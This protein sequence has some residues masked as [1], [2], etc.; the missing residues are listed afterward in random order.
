MRKAWFKRLG[1]AAVAGWLA[2]AG[3]AASTAGCASERE[4]INRVQPNAIRKSDLV[5]DFRDP[6]AAPEFYIRSVILA[7]HRTNPWFSDGLQDLTRRVRFEITDRFLIARNAYEFIKDSDGHGGVK[8]QANDGVVVSMWPITSHFQIQKS[9]N[10][11]TGE[12]TNVTEEN[13]T[14][15]PWYEREYM[16]VDWSRNLVSDPNQIFFWEAFA[17]QLTWKPVAYFENRPDHPESSNFAELGN[18]YFD[19]TSRWIASPETWDYYGY[20][21][22]SCLFR[23]GALYPDTYSEGSIDCG[24]QEVTLRTSF[25]KVPTGD[26]SSDY[27]V[28]EVTPWEGNIMG[29]LTMDRSGYDRNY[30]TTDDTWHKYI[31]RY[32]LWKK[33]HLPTV[34][35]QDNKKVDA[36]AVCKGVHT[37]ST[38][39]MNA[40]LCS[41]PYEQRE[42]KALAFYLD[43]ELPAALEPATKRAIG[44]WNLAISRAIAYARESEC[45]HLGGDRA[46]CHTKYFAGPIDPKKEDVPALKDGAA[47]V[48]CHNPVTKDDH[49]SCGQAGKKVRK[50]DIRHHMI[51]WWN[52]PSFNRPLGVIVWS[53]DPTTGENIGSLVNIFGA[54]VETYSASTRDQLQLIAG[55][56][57]PAEYAAGLPRQVYSTESLA[58]P[59]DPIND[60]IL[61]AY[62]T[63][64]TQGAKPAMSK[65]EMEAR[66]KAVDVPKLRADYGADKALAAAKTPAERLIA[67]NQYVA[68]QSTIGD[69]SSKFQDPAVYTAKIQKKVEALQKGGLE[70]KIMNDLWLS[71]VGMNPALAS[72]PEILEGMSPLRGM[73]P[74]AMA[75]RA[76][77]EEELKRKHSCSLELPEMMRFTW[78]GGYAAKLK[79]RYPDG[80]TA[81][82]EMAK[83]AGVEG[84]KIDRFVRGRLIYQELLE[85]MFE[86]TLLHEMGHLMSMEHDFSGSWDAPNF[87]PE[88]W[89]YRAQGDKAKMKACTTAREPGA[90]D[91]CMGPRW[92]DPATDEELGL[93]K[94]SEHDSL[95]AYAVSSV[96]DYKFDSLYAA[97]LGQFD[98]MAAKF[99]YTRQVELFDDTEFSLINNSRTVGSNFLPTLTILNFEGWLVGTNTNHY[100]DLARKLNLFDPGRCEIVPAE[101]AKKNGV[102]AVIGDKAYVCA[103]VHRDHSFLKDMKPELPR[104]G[105]P[106]DWKV[107]FAREKN[108]TEGGYADPSTAKS[109]WPYKAGDGRTSYVHQYVYDN[110]ADM[111]E[112][113]ADILERYELMYL[114][115]FF[116]KGGRERDINMAGYR[117]FSRFFER[118]QSLQWNALSDVVRSSGDGSEGADYD[119]QANLL[120]LTMLFDAMQKAFLRP[121]PGTYVAAKQPGSLFDVYAAMEDESSTAPGAFK[122]GVGDGR[123]IDHKYDLTKQF[124]YQAY[125]LRGGSFLE[126]PFAGI[127]LTDS[128]PQLSTVAR[129][130]YLDGRNV[131]FSFRSAIPQ[132]FDRLVAGVFAD[133]WDTIAPYVAP[134]AAPDAFGTVPTMPVKLWETDA[135]KISAAR[136]AGSRL[137]DPMLGYR[138]KVPAI[139]LM[140]LYQ[141]IDSSMDLINRTR[142]WIDGSPEAIKVPDAEKITFFDPVDG[143]EW[144]AKSFGKETLLGKVVDTGIGARMLEHANELMMAAY[145]VDTVVV[146]ATTGQK[147]VKYNPA[148]RPVKSTGGVIT[149]ADVKDPVAEKKLRDYVA[150][151][152]QVRVA[153]YYLG[154]GPCGYTY[155][156]DC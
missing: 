33:S 40:K 124:D 119:A 116:R 78:Q 70:P 6:K 4:E 71:S 57:T 97:K 111:Y 146:N 1:L 137:L 81:T 3:G 147:T 34:C 63:K 101:E 129:E 17:G 140:M 115:Y 47:V 49:P 38:C 67:W 13:T 122:V 95:D 150:F 92:L 141:P 24:D 7:V 42:I 61:N 135:A 93:K 11:A 16:R 35:G 113:T 60:P 65:A 106:D 83:R 100:T 73:N 26:Q 25:W 84:Q 23:N 151:L 114:D 58:Y 79:A 123:Y 46:S 105:F 64:L 14:D 154:F 8:G 102:G 82:G 98:K 120:A 107:K 51:A 145:D 77:K 80:A 89:A 130:T 85:P 121:Q 110:G 112:L 48:M 108:V 144:T 62:Q 53:G 9:Y 148:R 139:I 39:D 27:E 2:V 44:E 36:D 103:P 87:Y 15:L 142:V 31:M 125:P 91:D 21:I 99:I 109:R 149:A 104:G 94:G 43:P 138:I 69:P 68:K 72:K 41:M 126:K 52:N 5:G 45:R 32:N 18:G 127:A 132:A 86:F 90:P 133:D 74:T 131:M 50:G 155:D 55:D 76:A 117:M 96:M 22:P 134:G 20:Q 152:N 66:L 118:I 28:A 136:P 143:L 128:R 19:V 12:E 10:P 56:F 153:L 30:G 88:Y 37:D 75:L 54:S 59:T 156:R 29:N